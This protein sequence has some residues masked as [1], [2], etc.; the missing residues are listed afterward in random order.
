M[1]EVPNI[2]DN[3]LLDKLVLQNIHNQHINTTIQPSVSEYATMFGFS[4]F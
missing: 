1:T 4:T 3:V 2:F